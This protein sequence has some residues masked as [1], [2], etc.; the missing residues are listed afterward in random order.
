MKIFRS[1][2]LK[3][4]LLVM[5]ASLLWGCKN[6]ETSTNSNQTDT[7]ENTKKTENEKYVLIVLSAQNILRMNDN[8]TIHTGY[9]LDELAVPAQALVAAGYTLELATQDGVVPTMD[10]NSNDAVYFSNDQ[11][12]YKKALDFVKTYPAFSKPKKLSEVANSDL[13]K[14]SALFVPGGRAPMTDLMQS[15]DFGK[16]LRYVHEQN[17]TTAFLCHGPVALTAALADPVNYRKALVENDKSAISKFGKDWIYSGY[18]MAIF[19]NSEEDNA[20][21]DSKAKLPFY[22][23]DALK[24]AGGK[25]VHGENW[26]SFIIQDRELITGQ[27]PA[28]DHAI[29]D[30]LVK[31]LAKNEKE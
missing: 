27:N 3:L 13:N 24:F 31:A 28:S 26:K 25:T 10:K 12:A 7:M 9:F 5:A 14:Y 22:V 23:A 30:A 21:K 1:K 11:T 16:I 20:L 17:I 4:P 6:S 15:T 2:H 29:A 18:E 19:S 8:S